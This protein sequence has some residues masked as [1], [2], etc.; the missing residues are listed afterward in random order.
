[1][2]SFFEGRHALFFRGDNSDQCNFLKIEAARNA[3]IKPGAIITKSVVKDPDT[4]LKN[5]GE[6]ETTERRAR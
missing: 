3:G 5:I 6:G 2:H 4:N 1:M